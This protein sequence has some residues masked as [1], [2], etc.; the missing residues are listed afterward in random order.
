MDSSY[1]TC[2]NSTDGDNVDAVKMIVT[3][4]IMIMMM[5]MPMMM[6]RTKCG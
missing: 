3:I 6:T 5:V 4:I 1:P 2:D